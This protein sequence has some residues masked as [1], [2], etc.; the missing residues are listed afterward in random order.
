MNKTEAIHTRTLLRWLLPALSH[1]PAPTDGQVREAA[2]FLAGRAAHA[3]MTGP[4]PEQVE[5]AWH[6]RTMAIIE[7]ARKGRRG[8]S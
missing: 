4:S 6:E 2:V 7:D 3:L 5:K 1:E 8:S